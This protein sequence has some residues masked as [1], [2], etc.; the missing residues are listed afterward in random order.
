V[1]TL[2]NG[3]NQNGS[4]QITFNGQ[5]TAALTNIP[6]LPPNGANSVQ[7]AL[8][9]LSTIG[10]GNVRVTGSDG[11]PYVVE[12]IGTLAGRNQ[13]AMT[14]V[15]TG[16]PTFQVTTNVNGGTFGA[17]ASSLENAL[18][19]LPTKPPTVTFEVSSARNYIISFT[20]SEHEAR[21][22]AARRHDGQR[23]TATLTTLN[24]GGVR[25]RSCPSPTSKRS[26]PT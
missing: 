7:S 6:T 24:D 19:L 21:S 17:P 16:G 12:F 3:P 20:D 5:T 1:Q 11:G 4:F 13:P 18:N 8:E 26:T 23:L 9:A 14:V 10:V 2:T 22:A 15:N 25:A